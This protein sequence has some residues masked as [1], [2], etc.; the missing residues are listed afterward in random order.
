VST[1]E[2]RLRLGAAFRDLVTG[3][4]CYLDDLRRPGLAHTV[5]VRSPPK[6]TMSSVTGGET[7]MELYAL[8]FGSLVAGGLS[9]RDA[10]F[11]QLFRAAT[12]LIVVGAVCLVIF[13]RV[14]A[15]KS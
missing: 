15:S 9:P 10:V 6:E 12:G 4:E 7:T 13:A 3:Q 1:G 5:F 14:R 8:L 2:A 11:E